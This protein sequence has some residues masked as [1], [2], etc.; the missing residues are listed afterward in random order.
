MMD[1][2][3]L[4]A[5]RGVDFAQRA[6]GR[7]RTLEARINDLDRAVN[8]LGSGNPS[9]TE[10]LINEVAAESQSLVEE[11]NRLVASNGLDEEAKKLLAL[12][13]SSLNEVNYYGISAGA[14]GTRFGSFMRSNP[15]LTKLFAILNSPRIGLGSDFAKALPDRAVKAGTTIDN[16]A[17]LRKK[18]GAAGATLE[19]PADGE[20]RAREQAMQ[21]A[22][23]IQ[24]A[25]KET[26]LETT[27][28]APAGREPSKGSH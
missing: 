4:S 24:R 10:V 17:D 8:G 15:S 6:V 21:D 16:T 20:K 25:L 22:D 7:K 23:R 19:K 5:A 3:A 26:G 11:L 9:A 27:P 14:G 28:T 13:Q 1:R 2:S 18:I 12:A